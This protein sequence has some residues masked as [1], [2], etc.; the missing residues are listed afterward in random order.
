[1]GSLNT[2]SGAL[3]LS[4]IAMVIVF[5]VLG[6]LALMMVLIK[7]LA[8][9]VEA[10]RLKVK[11]E[12]KGVLREERE[13]REEPSLLPS[14]GGGD[15]KELVAIAAAIASFSATTRVPLRVWRVT[16]PI[17]SSWRESA[18]AESVMGGNENE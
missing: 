1:M 5:A 2:I 9:L 11:E 10:S 3:S 8:L 6:G 13:V 17:R 16:G 12:P 14:G 18:K 15:N 7:Y 4:V